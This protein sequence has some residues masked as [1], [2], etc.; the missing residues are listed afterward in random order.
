M[1][2]LFY[3]NIYSRLSWVKDPILQ[4]YQENETKIELEW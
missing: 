4:K 3:A 1:I 2:T